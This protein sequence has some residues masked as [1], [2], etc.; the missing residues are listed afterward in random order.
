MENTWSIDE[1]QEIW[2]LASTL[3]NGQKYGGQEENQQV[4]YINHIGSVTFE[5]LK[6]VEEDESLNPDL[7]IKCAVL[8]DTI[9]DTPY[10]LEE[11]EKQFGREVALGVSALTKQEN[12]QDIS[13]KMGDSLARIKEQPKEV[14]AV[15][16]ADRICNLSAP[17]FYWTNEKKIAYREEAKRIHQSLGEGSEYLG[18]RLAE[19]IERYKSFIK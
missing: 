1:L 17:P 9:E 4:E 6:A 8:H 11:V 12:N 13:D 14:W 19:K 10:S 18:N 5:I 2:Q 3:H 15:K 7:A 16:M